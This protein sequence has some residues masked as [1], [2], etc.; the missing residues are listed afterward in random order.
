M[1]TKKFGY[2]VVG[3]LLAL[4][5]AF[6]GAAVLAQVDDS[7]SDS[8][9]ETPAEAEEDVTPDDES[10]SGGPQGMWADRSE[11]SEALAEALGITVDEL[12]AAKEEAFSA[13]VAQ[14][15]ADGTLTQ[16]QADELLAD[17][18]GS[19]YH[20]GSGSNRSTER[21]Y[22]AD[23]LNISLEEL[24]AAYDE[25]WAAE[26]AEAVEAGDIT[27][28]EADAI[29]ARKS[30][31]DRID[32]EA[33]ESAAQEAYQAAVEQALADGV[34]T[35][36]Q[37]DTLLTESE[38]SFGAFGGGFWGGG[39]GRHRGG[40]GPHGGGRRGS[41]FFQDSAPAVEGVDA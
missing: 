17:G 1:L 4:G 3:G 37:A 27:Q 5:I 34:I 25:V 9:E 16:E 14:A 20:F 23:A 7:E 11:L 19:L 28:E 10:D 8:A 22:L 29:A 18:A 31:R 2:M 36:E 40:F 41:G 39:R 12:N 35:Q 6:G 30:V 24:Q 21:Q 13:M 38:S 26:L 32:Y 15:V 33:L